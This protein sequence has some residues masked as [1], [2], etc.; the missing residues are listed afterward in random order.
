MVSRS[1][2]AN[3]VSNAIEADNITAGF[4][5]EVV[6]DNSTISN[7]GTGLFTFGGD[8]PDVSNSNIAFNPQGASGAWFS[9]GNNRVPHAAPRAE[10]ERA[11]RPRCPIV[12]APASYESGVWSQPLVSVAQAAILRAAPS[13]RAESSASSNAR[14]FPC[15]D[16]RCSRWR[17]ARR[18]QRNASCGST[19]ALTPR[20]PISDC[21]PR[22]KMHARPGRH[23][24][25]CRLSTPFLASCPCGRSEPRLRRKVTTAI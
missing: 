10:N 15:I 4:G 1:L 7:N 8:V 23:N 20:P 16:R 3:N 19:R 14:V 18:C 2:I 17:S 24:R 6:V 25:R 22:L 21:R 11:L 13:S 5:T 9:F 12:A